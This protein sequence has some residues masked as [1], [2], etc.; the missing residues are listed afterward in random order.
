MSNI[1]VIIVTKTVTLNKKMTCLMLKTR[2]KK[3]MRETRQKTKCLTGG[4]FHRVL[5]FLQVGA[6]LRFEK[7]ENGGENLTMTMPGVGILNSMVVGHSRCRWHGF[8]SQICWVSFLIVSVINGV[9][10]RHPHEGI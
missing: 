8:E 6:K 3:L 4:S 9:E 7:K 1:F 5:T 2:N 10:L